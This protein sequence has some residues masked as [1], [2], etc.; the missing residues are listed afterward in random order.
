MLKGS[1]IW[2]NFATHKKKLAAHLCVTTPWLRTTD[3]DTIVNNADRRMEN[4]SY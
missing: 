1:K 2:K 4:D 3:L